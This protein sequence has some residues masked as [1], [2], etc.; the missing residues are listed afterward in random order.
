MLRQFIVLALAT[1]AAGILPSVAQAQRW[2]FRPRVPQP[3]FSAP[4][5][6]G[7]SFSYRRGSSYARYRSGSGG[8]VS[9]GYRSGGTTTS[10][11]ASSRLGR[12]SYSAPGGTTAS[13][14][15]R[16]GR[17]WRV[18]GSYSSPSASAGGYASGRAGAFTYRAPSGTAASGNYRSGRDWRVGGSYRSPTGVRGSGYVSGGS[19]A[20]DYR[21][22][23]GSSYEGS[24]RSGRDWRVAGG[25]HDAAGRGF[26]GYAGHQ[27]GGVGVGG[28]YRG[29]GPYYTRTRIG[30]N[31]TIAGR[32]SRV[33]GRYEV[34][35]PTGTARLGGVSGSLDR[36]GVSGR[37]TVGIGPVGVRNSASVRFAG[38]DTSVSYRREASAPGV[39]YQYGGT[40]S[41][42]GVAADTGA[43]LGGYRVGASATVNSRGIRVTGTGPSIR[44]P[45]IRTPR[46]DTPRIETPRLPSI[47]TPSLPR[48]SAP[49]VPSFSAPSLPS[50]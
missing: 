32:D 7:G 13:G 46:I 21:S 30:G 23:G 50:W 47:P 39:G 24:Y 49:S 44:T 12:F 2:S 3:R 17:D 26:S 5:S 9:G 6:P 45:H 10:G 8:Y 22:A 38:A 1:V 18:G 4:R 28:E 11:Y 41:R 16:S 37:R 25:Y 29:T 34:Y 40:I 42:R 35:D 43:R 48:V 27:P 31:A 19:G 20:F 15:Y 14:S 36:R 33:S